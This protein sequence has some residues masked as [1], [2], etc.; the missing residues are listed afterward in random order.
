[1]LVIVGGTGLNG[2]GGRSS[3]GNVL[4]TDADL[5]KAQAGAHFC[6]STEA[7]P[8]PWPQQGLGGAQICPAPRLV[9]WSPRPSLCL[10]P[11][12]RLL[13]SRPRPTSAVNFKLCLGTEDCL[14]LAVA[15]TPQRSSLASAPRL[16]LVFDR[17]LSTVD[18]C[19]GTKARFAGSALPFEHRKSTVAD[20]GGRDQSECRASGVCLHSLRSL[21]GFAIALQAP[22]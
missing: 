22:V 2:A 19:L 6:L 8:C 15:L 14:R 21:L 7:R 5:S 12:A 13:V 10:G 20:C 16:V 3:E 18:S 1:V 17:A 9:R 11:E 4:G